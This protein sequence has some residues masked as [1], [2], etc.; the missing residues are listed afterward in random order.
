M[1][2][3]LRMRSHFPSAGPR[4]ASETGRWFFWCLLWRKWC[5]FRSPAPVLWPDDSM[6]LL[7]RW[8]L[9]KRCVCVLKF[10]ILG[11]LAVLLSAARCCLL[12]CCGAQ[13]GHRESIKSIWKTWRPKPSI[14]L[15]P[16]LLKL[17][18]LGVC[19]HFWEGLHSSGYDAA[20]WERFCGRPDRANLECRLSNY[21][22]YFMFNNTYTHPYMSIT[23]P[24]KVTY[25][26][27]TG[28]VEKWRGTK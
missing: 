20:A 24:F 19:H 7:S 14:S 17:L 10:L 13:M 16:R 4:T 21:C 9:G 11:K 28:S 27:V 22:Y 26:G 1:E 2:K 23:R 5:V 12:S 25:F 3:C 15:W 8:Q 6:I 18:H